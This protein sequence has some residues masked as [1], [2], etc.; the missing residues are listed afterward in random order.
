MALMVFAVEDD[1]SIRELIKCTLASGGFEVSCFETGEELFFALKEKTPS[2]ILLDIMLT[3]RDGISILKELKNNKNTAYIPV[4]MLTAK[5]SEVDKVLGLS[6]GADDY[7][8]KPFGV[9]EL[10]ARIK[11]V[12]RRAPQN[13]KTNNF[14]ITAGDITIDP[15]KHI[16]TVNGKVVELTY[17]EFEI[18]Y[19]LMVNKGYAISRERLLDN[20]WGYSYIGETRTVDMHIK[21]LRQKLGEDINNPTHLL[22][23]RGIGYKFEG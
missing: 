12:T 13:D 4:I 19:F 6:E 5:S 17:K 7:I 23:V 1:S 18:L 8:A 15:E 20:I 14:I 21:S 11:A 3:G 16:V 2:V 10:I 22:T 9:L